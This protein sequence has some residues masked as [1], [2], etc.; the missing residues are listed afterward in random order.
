[1]M[2]SFVFPKEKVCYVL[3]PT[4]FEIGHEPP[5]DGTIRH[6]MLVIEIFPEEISDSSGPTTGKSLHPRCHDS[7]G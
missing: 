5:S 1:M 7:P 4:L 6:P 3:E 2:L